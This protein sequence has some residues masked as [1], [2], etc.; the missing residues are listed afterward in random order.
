MD[1]LAWVWSPAKGSIGPLGAGFKSRSCTR[2]G[3]SP[4]L[5]L[6]ILSQIAPALIAPSKNAQHTRPPRQTK[7]ATQG[8]RSAPRRPPQVFPHPDRL[9]GWS[10]ARGRGRRGSQKAPKPGAASVCGSHS[11]GGGDARLTSENYQ[12]GLLP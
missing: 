3:R 10:A 11:L 2:G 7:P 8:A 9:D 6:S 1:T 4:R 5:L 12:R